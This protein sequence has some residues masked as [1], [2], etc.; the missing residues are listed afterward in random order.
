MANRFF[1]K[2]HSQ[3][4]LPKLPKPPPLPLFETHHRPDGSTRRYGSTWLRR[5]RAQSKGGFAIA[6]LGLAH[7]WTSETAR[8]AALKRWRT[9]NRMNKLIGKRVGLPSKNR[10]PVDRQKLRVLYSVCP[11]LGIIYHQKMKQWLRLSPNGSIV[12]PL[13]ERWALTYLGHLGRQ[14]GRVP[15]EILA[16]VGGTRNAT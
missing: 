3:D 8:K 7:R 14:T 5:R 1:K 10:A 12:R 2:A 16:A 15:R 4:R 11:R 9:R 6:Q 13:S